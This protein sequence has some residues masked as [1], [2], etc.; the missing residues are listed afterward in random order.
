MGS[1]LP[2]QAYPMGG[3]CPGFEWATRNLPWAL[4]FAMGKGKGTVVLAK[5]DPS[6]ATV[7]RTPVMETTAAKSVVF[8]VQWVM[9]RLVPWVGVPRIA[10]W[11]VLKAGGMAVYAPNADQL[12]LVVVNQAPEHEWFGQ[13]QY[14]A[15]WPLRYHMDYDHDGRQLFYEWDWELGW[16]PTTPSW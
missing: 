16:H 13:P 2:P 5:M 6:V 7:F 14:K 4:S 11:P 8:E 1:D 3:V 10:R 12:D 9:T 15:F